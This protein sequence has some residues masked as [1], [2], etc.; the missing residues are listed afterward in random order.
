MQNVTFFIALG[1]GFL[2]FLSPCVLPL[3]PSYLSFISG[4]SLDELLAGKKNPRV[5]RLTII[6][7]LM[8]ILG[9]SIVFILLGAS[10]SL[11]G[12]I[13]LRYQV[14]IARIGGAFIVL[15]GVQFTGVINL[16]FLQKERKFHFREKPIGYLGSSLVGVAFAAGWTPCIGPILASILFY[17]STANS[18][19]SGIALLGVYSVGFALPFFFLSLGLETF[20]ER[21]KK[22]KRHLR[23][24]SIISGIFL[25]G[26]GI[27]LITN[28]FFIL[29]PSFNW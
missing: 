9:F 26:V 28:Y 19:L 13:L 17:A 15:L 18:M 4:I 8:F 5:R 22:L 16:N 1:A 2:S 20:L 12:K 21:Y 7:S 27:L 29:T 24:V 10:A 3:L 25:I 6:H 14:W 23:W 11:A